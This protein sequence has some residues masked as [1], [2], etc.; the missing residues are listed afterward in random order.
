MIIKLCEVCGKHELIGRQTKYC[1]DR[2]KYE[3]EKLLYRTRYY[4]RYKSTDKEKAR[5]ERARHT[6]V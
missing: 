1:S 4:P 6:I 5:R 2:C 3:V